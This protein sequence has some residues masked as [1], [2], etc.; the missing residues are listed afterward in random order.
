MLTFPARRHRRPPP[1][2]LRARVFC[3][4]FL[5]AVRATISLFAFFLFFPPTFEILP[6]VGA[7]DSPTRPQDGPAPRGPHP[8]PQRYEGA[9]CAATATFLWAVSC[10]SAPV[11]LHARRR[12][13]DSTSARLKPPFGFLA[14][15]NTIFLLNKI[16][17][18]TSSGLLPRQEHLVRGL[19]CR[20]HTH[21]RRLPGVRGSRGPGREDLRGLVRTE[22]DSSPDWAT[23]RSLGNRSLGNASLMGKRALPTGCPRQHPRAWRRLT[24]L[25]TPPPL[26]PFVGSFPGA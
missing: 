7:E 22:P 1:H 15:C 26:R 5:A 23:N 20:V 18:C 8:V 25:C 16:A 19:H 4:F 12:V 21:V 2:P 3:F 11:R 24:Y 17:Q 14:P 6:A 9:R 10:V 13:A